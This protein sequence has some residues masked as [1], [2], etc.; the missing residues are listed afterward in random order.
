[1]AKQNHDFHFLPSS[2]QIQNQ[3]INRRKG[4]AT[5]PIYIEEKKQ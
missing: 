1:M 4:A 2:T 3:L 5:Q